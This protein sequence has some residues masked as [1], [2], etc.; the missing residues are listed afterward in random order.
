MEKMRLQRAESPI[1]QLVVT[2]VHYVGLLTVK[3][4]ERREDKITITEPAVRWV[5]Y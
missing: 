5:L 2:A 4:S 1:I 3:N